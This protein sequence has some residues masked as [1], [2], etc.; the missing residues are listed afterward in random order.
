MHGQS[1]GCCVIMSKPG[2]D[3]RRNSCVSHS[4]LPC[5]LEVFSVEQGLHLQYL[6]KVCVMGQMLSKVS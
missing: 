3:E 4:V 5:M 2:T 6:R 1:A